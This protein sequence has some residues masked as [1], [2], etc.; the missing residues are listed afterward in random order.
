MADEDKTYCGE[1]DRNPFL[2][3]RDPRMQ[4]LLTKYAVT[5]QDVL[6]VMSIVGDSFEAIANYFHDKQDAY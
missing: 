6:D 1:Q 4:E 3:D 2:G 5:R